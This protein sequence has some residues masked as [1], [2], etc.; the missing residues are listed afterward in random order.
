[1]IHTAPTRYSFGFPLILAMAALL[2]L[3]SCTAP[4][5]KATPAAEANSSETKDDP[6]KASTTKKDKIKTIAEFEK[7]CERIDGLFGLLRNRKT[8]HL[9]LEVSKAQLGQEFIYFTYTHT[10]VSR[11]GQY[12]GR[13]SSNRL[14]KIEKHYDRLRFLFVDTKH[15]F[16]PTTALHKARTANIGEAV[17]AA[18]KIVA[19]N[20]KAGK[21]LIDA[22]SI[23]LTEQFSQIKRSGS[24]SKQFSLGKLS[25]DK[26]RYA[27]VRN[28]PKNTD[29]VVD[30]GYDNP[31][32]TAWADSSDGV[33]DS[34][35][36]TVRV[37]HTLLAMPAN[38]YKE[39]LDDPRIGYFTSRVT[40][41]TSTSATP[42]RDVVHRW[43]LKK[44]DPSAKLSEPIE[45][46]VWWIENTTPK[47]WRQTI[48]DA[49]LQWNLA[50]ETAGFKNAV[51]VKQQPDDADWDAGD[52]RYN[53]LRWVSSPNPPFGGYGPHYSNPR[54]GQI[55][56]ADIM[57]EWSFLSSRV[58]YKDVFDEPAAPHK[59][60]LHC[61]LGHE[62]HASHLAGRNILQ[63][64]SVPEIAQEKLL[65]DAMYY[66]IM[67]EVGHTLGLQ[68]NMRS[69]QL[70]AV[71]DLHNTQLTQRIG[72]TG[73]VMDYP[74]VNLA[75]PGQ[76]QGDYFT[77]RPGPY[78][79]WA[80]QFAY[81]PALAD[82]A[83]RE[84]LLSRSID[85]QLAFGNDADDMRSPGKAIDPRVM[86][87][88]IS[89]DAITW[90]DQRIRLLQ[91]TMPKLQ[92]SFQK[93]GRSLHALRNAFNSLQ[94]E[95][96][97]AAA[98]LSRYIGGI[99][100]DRTIAGQA[101]PAKPY[102]PVPMADQKR[103]MAALRRGVFAANAFVISDKLIANLRQQRRG[104]DFSGTTED[105]KIHN[106]ILYIQRRTLDHLFHSRV[107]TRI[108]D[109][110]LYGNQYTLTLMTDDL[111]AAIFDDDAKTDVTPQ[112]QML[113]ANYVRRVIS[114]FKDSGGV[115]D[116]HAQAIALAVLK[117]IREQLD[118]KAALK[119]NAE[120][121]AHSSHLLL[122]IR[123]AIDPK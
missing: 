122:L 80:I 31:A 114:M 11:V 83:K 57:L 55:L 119:I 39:Q 85:P 95:H 43:H 100:V 44:K 25:K 91:A 109:S 36:V 96:G 121:K 84:A 78:D 50:F 16:D 54:T 19:E 22:N 49:T 97:K 105:P 108:T 72:L 4:P 90:A 13:Y 58:R 66:L 76:K 12:R 67:H 64:F 10:G 71:K 86:I 82:P 110:R 48:R 89:S 9:Y 46:I 112:R 77:T 51:V 61:S 98:V 38:N 94:S 123:D 104:F 53:V 118:Q 62:L 116:D 63:A 32:P 101:A 28:Y 41:M 3:A 18:P 59:H 73:S 102:T 115:Y 33:I 24:S 14:F 5:S 27:S 93:K 15:Y 52:V 99:Y 37:Q 45:P 81:T 60:G 21:F 30:Y 79:L 35:Y 70:H 42:Y 68:H 40:D 103:A 17:L 107:I 23:F 88:D 87:R 113:Q 92:T 6:K 56:G 1:M 69:T 34:R 106:S 26:T 117:Q 7:D 75:T 47:K 2:P 111:T 20:K 29:L 8:G 120:T 65:K 74:G